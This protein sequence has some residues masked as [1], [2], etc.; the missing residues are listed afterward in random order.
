MNC[1]VAVEIDG[2]RWERNFTE[3]QVDH[4]KDLLA[5]DESAWVDWH[6]GSLVPLRTNSW[7]SFATDFFLPTAMNHVMKIDNLAKR[8]LAITG[9]MMWDLITF[10]IR[11][12]TCVPRLLSN[13]YRKDSE[14][15]K[16]IKLHCP[17]EM[18]SADVVKVTTK[19]QTHDRIEWFGQEVPLVQVPKREFFSRR[20]VEE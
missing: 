10:P 15:K 5:N 2:L 9:A 11:L 1:T 13:A 3:A 17:A 14:I 4:V 12:L 19:K 16:F 8:I 7:K 18:A 6:I 20:E